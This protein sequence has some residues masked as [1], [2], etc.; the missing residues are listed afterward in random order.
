[1][2]SDV[3]EQEVFRVMPFLTTGLVDVPF[4]IAR[5]I[6]DEILNGGIILYTVVDVLKSGTSISIPVQY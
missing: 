5:L 3:L 4:S 1:M 6:A 2:S